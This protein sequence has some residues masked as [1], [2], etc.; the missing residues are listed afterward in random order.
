MKAL[1]TCCLI[2][3][4]V[5]A[6]TMAQ[7]LLPAPQIAPQSY[8][9]AP[10]PAPA[11]PIPAAPSVVPQSTVTPVPDVEPLL[12]NY[13]LTAVQPVVLYPNVRVKDA[14]KIHPLA[15]PTIVEVPDPRSPLHRLH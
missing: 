11:D 4:G 13:P 14:R 6:D 1:L 5:T 12:P 9:I 2:V 15:V 10:A 3:V 8:E 7:E